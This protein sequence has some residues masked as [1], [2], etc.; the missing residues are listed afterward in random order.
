M[1][2]FLMCVAA[3]AVVVAAAEPP[4][5]AQAAEKAIWG[6]L[7]RPDGRSAMPFYRALGVDTLQVQLRFA[8][9]AP[10]RPASPR[11]P[12]DPAYRWPA[13]LDRAVVEA[14]RS[15]IQIALLVTRS[16]AW[17]NGGRSQLWVPRAS[18]YADFLTAASRRYSSVRRWQIWGEPNSRNAF[19]PNRLDSPVGPRA[20]AR[21]LD[22]GYV[23]LKRVSARNIVIGG[24]TFS[25]GD[26]KPA[27]FLRFMKLPSG[28]R[29]RLDWFGHNP[30]PFGYP[31]L[32]KG[33][34]EGAYRDISDVGVFAE[35]V[36]RAYTRP[37]GS[38]GE[39]RCGPRPKL[40]LSEFTVQSDQP[41]QIFG[42]HVSRPA[43]GRWLRAA[44]EIADSLPSI[45]GLGWFS[46]YDQDALSPSANWGLLT[47]AGERKPA[48]FA[49]R[50]APSV[51][52][53]PD[54][55][56]LRSRLRALAPDRRRPQPLVLVRPRAKGRVSAELRSASG[57]LVKR[58]VVVS[59]AAGSRIRLL[60]APRRLRRGRYTIVV[61]AARG[62]RVRRALT[63]R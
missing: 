57:G 7:V 50:R 11:D 21:I 29:P 52:L 26:V 46:L 56:L 27:D 38:N 10:T 9:A 8:D 45:A 62:E 54:V 60:R 59:S 18:A 2:R 40:W 3:L 23:A 1:K 19:L 22:A 6:P 61:D 39:R 4:A 58:V 30:F 33:S 15:G 36:V 42:R 28:R 35:E 12:D 47:A 24:M 17:A 63:V 53:R 37:C 16:P 13:R 49:Y 31:D 43:Q 20:Y 55:R 25:A 32:R 41:S 5:A 48:Y 51:A 14:R 34:D 44:F